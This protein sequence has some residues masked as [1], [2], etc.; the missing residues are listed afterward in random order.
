MTENINLR[1]IEDN[2]SAISSVLGEIN[3]CLQDVSE[4]LKAANYLKLAELKH[5]KVDEKD[6]KTAKDYMD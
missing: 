6:L 4:S 3:N 1:E 2:L 5:L